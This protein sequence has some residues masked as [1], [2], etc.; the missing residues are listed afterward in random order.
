M[1]Q[2]PPASTLHP[3]VAVIS[4]II[5]RSLLIRVVLIAVMASLYPR[6]AIVTLHL[7]EVIIVI[8]HPRVRVIVTLE[9]TVSAPAHPWVVT[10][11][12]VATNLLNPKA[13]S[14]IIALRP[15]AIGILPRVSIIT[16]LERIRS[17]LTHMWVIAIS[18]DLYPRRVKVIIIVS[19]ALH[20]RS[21]MILLPPPPKAR[22]K[23][24]LMVVLSFVVSS[25]VRHH[26]RVPIAI[27][28]PV[29]P[30]NTLSISLTILLSTLMQHHLTTCLRL[31]LQKAALLI[32]LVHLVHISPAY[33]Q[34]RP[35]QHLLKHIGMFHLLLSQ[36]QVVVV[37]VTILLRPHTIRIVPILLLL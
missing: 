7:R 23:V 5:I 1:Q 11:T 9:R 17:S 29:A 16:T 3:R 32:K 2:A 21:V 12:I 8:R 37:V 30:V 20:P 10:I 27:L 4:V 13:V 24:I 18:T 31:L 22:L 35:I 34:P 25:A 14:I 28:L 33:F 6:I 26:I 36:P 15:R 19:L